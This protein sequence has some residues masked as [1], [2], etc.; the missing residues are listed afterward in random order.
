MTPT[1]HLRVH[2]FAGLQPGPRLLVT[3]AVHGNEIHGTQ[4]MAE[5]IRQLDAGELTLLRGTLTLVP[6]VNPLAN[7]LNRR[8]GDRNLNRN[9][10]PPVIAHD[11][12]DRIARVLCPLIARHD[13]LLDLHSFQ[14]QG[15]AFAMIGPRNN[16]GELEPFAQ[17]ATESALAARLGVGRIVEGWLSTYA[18]GL[19]RRRQRE[20]D[21]SRRAALISDP[22]YGV[23][24]TEYMR[25]TGGWAI[26][27]ECGQHLDPNGPEVARLAILRALV[28]LGMLDEGAVEPHRPAQAPELL[29]LYDVID[30]ED[31]G[32]SFER[33][34]A[35]FDAIEKGQK[36]GTRASGAAVLAP[37]EGRI[38]FPNV[39]SQPGTEWFY[40]ARPSDRSLG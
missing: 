35:S 6:I 23:G 40:L 25:S 10:R 3:G 37:G 31:M 9:L 29:Q 5:I 13:G 22:H 28:F 2:Q 39:K 21:G 38:V 26:T 36:I 14:G 30:R 34:W 20:H 11:Y 19:Q 8:E 33:E 17:E 32:D 4:A 27:L 18:L 15:P 7:Q 24:T 12:E 1:T 16:A